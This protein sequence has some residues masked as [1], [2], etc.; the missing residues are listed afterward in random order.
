MPAEAYLILYCI[1][2]LLASLAGGAIPMIV[3]L[4]HKRIQ[5]AISLVALDVVLSLIIVLS[6]ARFI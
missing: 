6:G 1:V 2:I 4:T 5:V 3:R